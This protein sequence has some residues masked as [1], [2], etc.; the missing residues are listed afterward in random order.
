MN[1]LV[2]AFILLALASTCFLAVTY[3]PVRSLIARPKAARNRSDVVRALPSAIVIGAR[4][5]G[6]R[7]LLDFLALHPRVRP[8]KQEVHF[9][10]VDTN[11]GKGLDWY[12]QQMPSVSKAKGEISVE[13]SP[14]Y[15]VTEYVPY[16]IKRMDPDIRLLL[17]V[18]DPVTRLISD[19]SQILENH[20]QL[21][22]QYRP[23]DEVVLLRNGS[24]NPECEAVRKSEYSRYMRAWLKHF[25]MANFHIVNG[26]K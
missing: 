16:R 20:R 26:D 21:Q 17:I 13:K 7:A 23:F 15:F 12:R 3:L 19:Y 14:S 4:K 5:G 8:A 25:T 1:G 10:D 18:R 9:F 6:T 11:Y 2:R 22:L 24:V